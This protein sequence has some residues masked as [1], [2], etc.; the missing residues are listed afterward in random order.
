MDRGPLLPGGPLSPQ[1]TIEVVDGPQREAEVEMEMDLVKDGQRNDWATSSEMPEGHRKLF[2]PLFWEYPDPV[3]EGAPGLAAEPTG[4]DYGQ[5]P[6]EPALSGV[7]GDWGSRWNKGWD[8]KDNSGKT[9]FSPTESSNR[10][11][12]DLTPPR[13]RAGHFQNSKHQ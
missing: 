13:E 5:D 10:N 6:E 3:E 12:H 7:G 8:I 11:E 2:W 1:V 9:G 4:R